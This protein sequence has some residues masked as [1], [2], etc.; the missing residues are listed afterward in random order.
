MTEVRARL[1]RAHLTR[2]G[3]FSG[4]GIRAAGRG[5]RRMAEGRALRRVRIGG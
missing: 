1:T 5:R 2:D 4:D 3:G